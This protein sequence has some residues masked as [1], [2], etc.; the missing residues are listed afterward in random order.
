MDRESQCSTVDH[1]APILFPITENATV[2][3][4]LEV[5]QKATQNIGQEFTI[6]TFDLGVAKKV[7][8]IL[9]QNHIKFGNV[10]IKI[11]VFHTICSLFGAM[12]KH[13]KGSGFEEIIIEADVCAS[14]SLQKVMLGKHYNRALSVHKLVLEVLERLL[15]EVFQDHDQSREGR[16]DE[17]ENG[18]R[19]RTEKPDSEQFQTL[20][21]SRDFLKKT[22]SISKRPSRIL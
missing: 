10:I 18:L 5:S 1:M 11:G 15:F 7:F 12:G 2:Q 9:W 4:V 14:G 21:T 13:M 8:N 20:I 17:S 22:F 3:H 6:V 19:K 16:S